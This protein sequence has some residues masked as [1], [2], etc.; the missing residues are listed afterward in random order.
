MHPIVLNTKF[1]N[2]FK[3]FLVSNKFLQKELFMISFVLSFRTF[4]FR[5]HRNIL[6]DLM[7]PLWNIRLEYYEPIY[8]Q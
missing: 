6:A 2:G 1:D 4:F 3:T 7:L 8:F 5:F